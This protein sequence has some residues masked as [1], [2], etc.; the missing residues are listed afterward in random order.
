MTEDAQAPTTELLHVPI[1]EIRENPV[2]LRSVNRK[3]QEFVGL[4]QSIAQIGVQ[5][6]ITLQRREDPETG[7]KYF[8]LCDGLQRFTASKELGNSTIPA[9]VVSLDQATTLR[10]QVISNFHRVKTRPM[11]MTKQLQRL[12]AMDCLLTEADLAKQLGATPKW[13][14]DRLGLTKITNPEI[15][16]LVNDGDIVLASAYALAKLPPEEQMNFLQAAV[17][18]PPKEFVALVEARAKEIKEAARKGKDPAPAAFVAQP[19][20]QK[21]SVIKT[22][23]ADG[24]VGQATANRLHEAGVIKA[25]EIAAAAAGFAEGIKWVS[26]M[27]A[28]SVAAAEAKWEQKRKDREEAKRKKAM[29]KAQK[30]A[31]KDEAKAKKSAQAAAAAAAAGEALGVVDVAAKETGSE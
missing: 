4:K 7:E 31:A 30:Q 2:A 26:Q 22:E 23:L 27:D 8:E 17:T 15:S 13:I 18:E 10:A 12:L 6:A 29:E 3:G 9:Q 14:Q 28:A 11:E 19:H 5:N 25:E 21:L 24:A 16:R 20:L 1:S